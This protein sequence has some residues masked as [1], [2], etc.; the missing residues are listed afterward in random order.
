MPGIS[1]KCVIAE[2]NHESN[3]ISTNRLFLDRLS[4]LLYNDD[5][6]KEILL[7]ED[8][9]LVA[10]TRYKEY[11]VKIIETDEFW[12][13][14]EGKIY[15]KTVPL[16]E[17][18]IRFLL[19]RI[20]AATSISK[21][22]KNAIAE[23]LLTTD[24]DFILY[25]LNK[26]TKDFVIMNDVL[27]RLP[28]Y[29][30]HKRERGII[31]SREIQLLGDSIN[32]NEDADNKFDKIGLA[33]VLLFSHTLGKRT[34]LSNIDRLEPASL[35]RIHGNDLTFEIEHIYCFNFQV[36]ANTDLSITDN[37]NRLISLFSEACKNRADPN[38]RN[39]ISLSGGFDSRAVAA[40][41]YKNNILQYAVTSTEPHWRPVEGASSEAEIAGQIAKSLN[42]DWE[43]YGIKQPLSKDII[44]LLNMKLG[45]TYLA[46][47][48]LLPFIKE[49]KQ[50]HNSRPINFFT[51][52][53]G[54]ILFADSSYETSNV[55][56]LVRNIIR[57]KG[58]LP[59]S[60][61]VS[62][63]KINESEIV[64]EIRKILSSYPEVTLGQKLAHYLFF[65]SNVKFSFEIEDINRHYFWTLAPFYSVPF[66][67]YIMN[68]PDRQKTKLALYREFLFNIS[69]LLAEIK[70]SNWGCS[71]L[72]YKFRFLQYLMP[73]YWRFSDLRKFIKK[74]K[75]KRNYS[76]RHDS[77]IIRCIR[78]Q[79]DN[80]ND[81]SNLLSLKVIEK[82]TNNSTD[83]THYALD[84]LFTI[85]SIVERTL[86]KNTM[87]E[88]Y[89]KE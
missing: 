24:G 30:H 43:D 1:L 80:C 83:Y 51:G 29:Y 75:D 62:I 45:L 67:K 10:C 52:H 89:Y 53:G 12:V 60:D 63:V 84:N 15:N 73:F 36:K 44:K 57:V 2:D 48:F 65:E 35:L 54:D 23:W 31:A 74:L 49:V 22:D 56:H 32:H 17:D 76:Y 6:V 25:A 33:E 46:H 68:C 4:T 79:A 28:F 20:F 69:P 39:I 16:L 7:K 38:S 77:K 26:S 82:I 58:Y 5:Y 55:D 14:V 37:A 59:L 71:I 42:I 47:S 61:A 85:T 66:F 18:E 88:K 19:K 78:D 3:D 70:N 8:P 64:E 11:P 50:K 13:C 34:L 41:L 40:G 21:V 27:G 81:I 87:I 86:C 9:Y 72:S